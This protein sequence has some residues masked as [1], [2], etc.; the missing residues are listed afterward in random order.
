MPGYRCHTLAGVIALIAAALIS[1]KL[2]LYLIVE[3][4]IFCLAGALFPDLDITSRGRNLYLRF[5]PF[6]IISA[7]FCHKLHV[8]VLICVYALLMYNVRHR[9]IFHRIWFIAISGFIAAYCY[10]ECA[11]NTRILVNAIF[12]LVG[13]FTHVVLDYGLRKR[14]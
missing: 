1:A 7:F 4:S 8:I 11:G 9:G 5:M 6:F 12:F 14:R 2:Q 13:G 3:R 10:A